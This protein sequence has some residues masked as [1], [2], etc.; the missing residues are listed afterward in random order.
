MDTAQSNSRTM[1]ENSSPVPEFDVELLLLSDDA[2]S[3]IS[4][5][6]TDGEGL[7]QL[8]LQFCQN[9]LNVVYR[10]EHDRVDSS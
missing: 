4:S 8:V 7:L 9:G 3:A 1:R 5:L 2:E 6:S 10:G